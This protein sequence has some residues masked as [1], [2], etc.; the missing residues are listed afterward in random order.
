M[1]ISK[2]KFGRK[3]HCNEY[4]HKCTFLRLHV[5]C[6]AKNCRMFFSF[7]RVSAFFLVSILQPSLIDL[8]DLH[9]QRNKTISRWHCWIVHIFF[10][11]FTLF[12]V[13]VTAEFRWPPFENTATYYRLM[14]FCFCIKSTLC[15]PIGRMSYHWMCWETTLGM[16]IHTNSSTTDDG[17]DIY[18]I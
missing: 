3:F 12:R 13:I 10:I 5:Y 8:L 2:F 18:I 11:R 7:R 1:W 9:C 15:Q 6:D 4:N 17:W 14:A 16:I